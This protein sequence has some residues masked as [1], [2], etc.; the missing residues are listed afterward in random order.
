MYRNLKPNSWILA[1]DVHKTIKSLLW[2]HFHKLIL[3]QKFILFNLVIQ[4]INVLFG[5]IRRYQHNK[6]NSTGFLDKGDLASKE[7]VYFLYEFKLPKLL[8]GQ[9]EQLHFSLSNKLSE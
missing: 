1:T 3:L 2:F 4:F 5:Y 7:N 9:A 6:Y 8:I